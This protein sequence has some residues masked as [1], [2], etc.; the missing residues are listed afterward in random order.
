[1]TCR[2]VC[3]QAGTSSL[4]PLRYSS[5]MS[6]GSRSSCRSVSAGSQRRT[7]RTSL[8]WNCAT[9]NCFNRFEAEPQLGAVAG[10]AGPLSNAEGA[11]AGSVAW[12]VAG[13]NSRTVAVGS[14][15]GATTRPPRCRFGG[16]RV[17]CRRTRADGRAGMR[18][19]LG[20]EVWCSW[21]C[22]SSVGHRSGVVED[23]RTQIIDAH[24]R[25]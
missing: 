21:R 14:R 8:A 25:R 22:L 17:W 20:W 4:R 16:R 23:P 18:R 6:W 7:V 1:M 2:H 9:P 12:G 15:T 10:E 3:V 24:R 5:T 11:P 19:R 13:V